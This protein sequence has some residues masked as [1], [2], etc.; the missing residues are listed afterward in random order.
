MKKTREEVQNIENPEAKEVLQSELKQVQQQ[1]QHIPQQLQ[2]NT[3]T[4]QG[5]QVPIYHTS[6]NNASKGFKARNRALF[7]HRNRPR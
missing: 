7:K 4:N 6:I 5:Q 1:P 3:P 2:N